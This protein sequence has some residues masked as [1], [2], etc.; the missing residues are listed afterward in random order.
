MK[1]EYDF[2]NA[3]RGKFFQ[4]DAEFHFPVYLEADVDDFLTKLAEEKGLEVD[5]LVNEWLRANIQLIRDY[6]IQ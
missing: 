5:A 6:A 3:E 4:Q 2:S 1:D